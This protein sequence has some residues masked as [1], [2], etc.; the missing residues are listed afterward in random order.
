[1][2][3]GVTILTSLLAT[4][5]I[6]R[7]LGPEAYGVFV[8][9]NSL[10]G[11]L[12]FADLG[13]G[14]ASTRFAAEAHARGEDEEEV[15]VLWTGLVLTAIPAV[16]VALAVAW[17]AEFVAVHI[18]HLPSNLLRES[19]LALRLSSI[20]VI[21]ASLAG[22]LNTPQIV[23]L[24]FD[25]HT[26][27]TAGGTLLQSILI[28]VAV[29]RGFDLAVI[30]AVMGAVAVLTLGAHYLVA[31]R[32]LPRVGRPRFS[33][34]LAGRMFRFGYALL[35]SAFTGAVVVHGER[36]ALAHFASVR[37]VAHYA[38]AFAIASL[39]STVA[40]SMIQPLFS[41][42]SQLQASEDWSPLGV[43]Y[44]R[45]STVIFVC[46]IPAIG[47]LLVFGPTL[48]TH[49]AGAEYGTASYLPLCILTGAGLFNGLR[50][51]N[52]SMLSALGDT[53]VLMRI[54]VFEV[55]PYG[56]ILCVGVILFGVNGAALA[57]LLRVV[58]EAAFLFFFV[59][60]RFGA[61][62][63]TVVRAPA[64]VIGILALLFLISLKVAVSTSIP[65]LCCAFAGVLAA[66]LGATWK[67]VLTPAERKQAIAVMEQYV[68]SLRR[69][70]SPSVS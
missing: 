21:A 41:A 48:L 2:S 64:I 57:F 65:V 5:L 49:W 61:T 8:L 23:R 3:Q 4:P 33:R 51:V 26:S 50:M 42:F 28:V 13:M 67:G 69:G 36:L 58:G 46:M 11:Y 25:L 24:R 62:P 68:S 38:V 55:L 56:A 54:N 17:N 7:G 1:M 60:K 19:I 10:I 52:R 43:L 45:A 12:G 44:T 32:I 20:A 18:L 63:V 70:H 37:E 40:T 6:L 53:E 14:V 39:V 59:R 34:D 9:L 35:I 29:A 27:I 22:V 66:Y 16:L 15:T 30:S 47:L 31:R